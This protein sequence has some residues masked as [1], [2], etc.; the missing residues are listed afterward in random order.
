MRL[1]L[2]H[3]FSALCHLS[4]VLCHPVIV[5]FYGSAINCCI[6][7]IFREGK[8]RLIKLSHQIY[9]MPN[10]LTVGDFADNYDPVRAFK[11][12]GA[13]RGEDTDRFSNQA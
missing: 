6:P 10:K 13:Y 1:A 7:G 3:W 8:L 11:L 2:C 9:C 12:A 5:K 4:S